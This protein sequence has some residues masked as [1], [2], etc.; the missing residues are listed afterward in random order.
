MQSGAALILNALSEP[1]FRSSSPG[2]R[3]NRSPITALRQV[4]TAY[5][6]GATW[7]VEGDITDCFDQSS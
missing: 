2:F 7:I 4:S 3:P 6:A 5:R 1:L